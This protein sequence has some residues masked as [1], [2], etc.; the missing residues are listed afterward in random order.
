M[1]PETITT[2]CTTDD[3]QLIMSQYPPHEI[4]EVLRTFNMYCKFPRNSMERHK[5]SRKNRY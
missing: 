3:T 5:K 4:K 1:K 2:T